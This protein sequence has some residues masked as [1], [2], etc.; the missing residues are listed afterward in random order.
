[1]SDKL[2]NESDASSGEDTDFLMRKCGNCQV[3]TIGKSM[4]DCSGCEMPICQNC[5]DY[6]VTIGCE[7]DEV[8]VCKVC[9]QNSYDGIH[10][11]CDDSDCE[12]DNV[13]KSNKKRRLQ[14]HEETWMKY[15]SM[16]K[17]FNVKEWKKTHPPINYKS[18]HCGKW[19][20]DLFFSSNAFESGYIK[21]LIEKATNRLKDQS[22][23]EYNNFQKYRLE[24][25]ELNRILESQKLRDASPIRD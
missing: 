2:L 11:Y 1:M 23:E 24:A 21:W 9:F 6:S 5:W 7:E 17:S 15:E 13:P 3:R 16:K 22:D 14:R 10:Q 12:C 20:V 4:T 25:I 8:R 19:L 18:T